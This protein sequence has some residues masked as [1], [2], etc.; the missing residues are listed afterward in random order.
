MVKRLCPQSVQLYLTSWLPGF[1]RVPSLPPYLPPPSLLLSGFTRD[2]CSVIAQDN[3]I[4]DILLIAS[5]IYFSRL[6]AQIVSPKTPPPGWVRVRGYKMNLFSEQFPKFLELLKC[7]PLKLPAPTPP[8]IFLLIFWA[9]HDISRLLNFWSS[10]LAENES[11][12]YPNVCQ[13]WSRSDDR[14][15]KR[16]YG[17]THRQ[18]DAAALYS[19]FPT[20]QTYYIKTV[21]E[22]FLK[23]PKKMKIFSFTS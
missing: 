12:I 21:T 9:V 18:R 4:P 11:H 13:I 1:D 6:Y 3:C 19:R 14:V 5:P 15:V 22:D 2:I 16:G 20:T 17:E 8:V 7:R 10:F 23:K